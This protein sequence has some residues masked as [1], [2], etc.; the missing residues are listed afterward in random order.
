[1]VEVE[2]QNFQSIK[3]QS[4][5]VD[6][7]TVLVGRSNLGKSAFVRAIQYAVS[8]A[9]GSDFVRHRPECE[10][11]KGRKKCKCFSTVRIKTSEMEIIW[12]KGDS[13]NSYDL[14]RAGD[15][16]WS[17]YTKVG[18]GTPEFLYPEFAPVKVGS[19]GMETLQVSE[20]F[21]PIF[22]LNQS[23][24]VVADVLSNVARLDDINVAMAAVAKDRKS[25][26]LTRKLREKDIDSLG[27]RLKC[28]DGLDEALLDVGRVDSEYEA[29][30]NARDSLA[31]LDSFLSRAK[32]LSLSVK[33]L[34]HALAPQ[35]P[36]K[37]AL[38]GAV[39][40]ASLVHKLYDALSTKAPV[41]RRLRGI[42]KVDL[43]D[44]QPVKTSMDRAVKID[45]WID[46]LREVKYRRDRWKCLDVVMP[47]VGPVKESLDRATVLDRLA[48]KESRLRQSLVKVEHSLSESEAERSNIVEEINGLGICPTC[49][50]EIEADRCLHLEDS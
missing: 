3:H 7:F 11:R 34:R 19:D 36:D 21:N 35:E 28:Y 40:R 30:Q 39:V 45:R 10:R 32:S 6:G 2:I 18:Q 22:L 29:I 20:Q 8:G 16:D 17:V 41:V 5:V 12:K 46:R 37:K 13:V 1:M 24:T 14:K 31:K 44:T 26:V 23:G 27:Q 15:E 50:Q 49:S 9:S 42:D 38:K 43:P 4:I 33:G 47:D 48:E 25:E